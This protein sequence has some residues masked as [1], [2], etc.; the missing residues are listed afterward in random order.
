LKS[1]DG[2][3]NDDVQTILCVPDRRK[4]GAA[5]CCVKP[6]GRLPLPQE[7]EFDGYGHRQP[8][9]RHVGADRQKQRSEGQAIHETHETAAFAKQ[10]AATHHVKPSR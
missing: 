6:D 3:A 1:F 7:I 10:G 8:E 9:I 2:T 5:M 4:K